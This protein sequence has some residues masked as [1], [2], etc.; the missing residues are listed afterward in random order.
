MNERVFRPLPKERGVFAPLSFLC[1]AVL[2]GA[3]I[4]N[5]NLCICVGIRKEKKK[6][7]Y[8]MTT[9]ERNEE[10]VLCKK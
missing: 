8:V 10:V 6:R 7:C 9:D 2:S 5:K 4:V 1:Y 3:A